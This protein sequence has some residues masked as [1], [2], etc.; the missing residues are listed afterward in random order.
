MKKI[1]ISIIALISMSFVSINSV[2]AAALLQNSDKTQY[3][4]I[5]DKSK[6]GANNNCIDDGSCDL[7]DFV[8][9][10]LRVTEIMLGLVGSI[11]LLMFV[12]GGVV[13]L[14]SGGSSQRVEQGKQIII[15]SVIGLIIV[16]ASYTIIGFIFSA[17]GI[18]AGW[19]SSDWFNK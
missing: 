12:Y 13:F 5:Q 3:S 10:G 1:S 15:G 19:A 8:K 7:N 2:S 16:F 9:V 17:S 11:S 4:D 6:A 14:I 18:N